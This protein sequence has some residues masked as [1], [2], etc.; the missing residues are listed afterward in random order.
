MGDV[1]IRKDR[2]FCMVLLKHAVE[3]FCAP[4]APQMLDWRCELCRA[5]YA[6]VPGAPINV[7]PGKE[8]RG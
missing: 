5:I 3:H 6:L 8:P 4:G 7:K 1:D 2:D